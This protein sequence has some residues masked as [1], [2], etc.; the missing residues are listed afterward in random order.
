M[1]VHYSI[2]NEMMQYGP[3]NDKLPLSVFKIPT[4]SFNTSLNNWAIFL[5]IVK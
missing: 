2:K 1:S 4:K 5:N 3:H